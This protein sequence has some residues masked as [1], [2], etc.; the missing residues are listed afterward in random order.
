MTKQKRRFARIHWYFPCLFQLPQATDPV[1][2]VGWGVIRNISMRGAELATRF[3]VEAD[4]AIFLDFQLT[5]KYK[6]QHIPARVARIRKQGTFF[7]CGIEFSSKVDFV[8]LG[9]ALSDFLSLQG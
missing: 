7:I 9:N 8:N 2:K 1:K 6:F 4:Q 5:S 3:P